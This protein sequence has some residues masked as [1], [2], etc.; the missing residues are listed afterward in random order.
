V[1]VVPVR[2]MEPRDVDDVFRVSVAAFA[3]LER[4]MG[5]PEEPAP[6]I[7][8][9]RIRMG[10]PLATD[11]GGAWVAER[12]GAVVGAAQA[13]VREGL[14]GLSLLIVR[15]EAQSAGIGR[16][17]LA[18]AWD[19]GRDA[20]GWIVLS[21]GDQRAMRSYARLGLDLHPSLVARGRPRAAVA[22]P[23]VRPGSADDLP[24]TEAVDRGVRGAAHGGDILAL[25]EAGG[26]MLVLPDRGYAVMRG[27]E[28]RV[29]AAFDDDAAAALLRTCF[30]EAGGEVTAEFITGAQQWAFAPCLDAGLEL[31]PWGA[32]FLG[33]DVGPFT[34]YLPNGAYL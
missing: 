9:A 6:P 32:V 30:A 17:L 2:P 26:R 22:D 27:D 10:R 12:G 21:S 7:G 20:R 13:I 3:D 31:H 25:L 34:P 24:L 16:E 23:A 11:P 5:V 29:L 1:R 15:P 28:L 14:W 4:R 19:Y 8:A 33:G 18:R